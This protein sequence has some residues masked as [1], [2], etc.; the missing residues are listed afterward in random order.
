MAVILLVTGPM[1]A[2]FAMSMYRVIKESTNI[3]TSSAIL[4]SVSEPVVFFFALNCISS[5]RSDTGSYKS[6]I[7]FTPMAAFSSSLAGFGY[8][9]YLIYLTNTTSKE[10]CYQVENANLCDINGNCDAVKIATLC[11]GDIYINYAIAAMQILMLLL[12]SMALGA[13]WPELRR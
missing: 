10:S 7:K 13:V 1:L 6:F 12:C 5:T 9:V 2:S 11:G 8:G 3:Q 4:M